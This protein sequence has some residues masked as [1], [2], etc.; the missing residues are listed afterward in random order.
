MKHPLVSLLVFLLYFAGDI[1][2]NI[3]NRYPIE[4]PN[5]VGYTAHLAGV[6][7]GQFNCFYSNY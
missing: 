6:L 5:N 2:A 1:G 4:K 3:M 7:A